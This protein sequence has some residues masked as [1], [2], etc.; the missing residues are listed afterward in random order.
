MIDMEKGERI[1]ANIIGWFFVIAFAGGAVIRGWVALGWL[2]GITAVVGIGYEI[3]KYYNHGRPKSGAVLTA[4][5]L[6]VILFGLT[7]ITDPDVQEEVNEGGIMIPTYT[8]TVEITVENKHLILGKDY[9]L[10][11]DGTVISTF[12]LKAWENYTMTKTITWKGSPSKTVTFS[13]SSSGAAEIG[14]YNDS[15]TVYLTDESRKSVTLHA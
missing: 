15:A 5:C 14:N 3:W 6:V 9:S 2:F 11:Q 12:H 4:V 10:E 8:A 1:A 13:V 7:Y